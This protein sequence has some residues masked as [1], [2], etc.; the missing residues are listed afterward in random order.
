MTRSWVGLAGLA[1][2]VVALLCWSVMFLTVHDVWH[3]VG[4]PDI[5]SLQGP[6]YQDLRA[7]AVAFYALAVALAAQALVAV[8]AFLPR[9]A[10]RDRS[11][12]SAS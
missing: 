2:S 9:I 8:A 5:W 3:D 7:F 11:R 4:R 6:P 1:L 12:A 10:N